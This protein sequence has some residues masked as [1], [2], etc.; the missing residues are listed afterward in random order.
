MSDFRLVA[1][2]FGGP[3]VIEAV[4]LEPIALSPGKVRVRHHAV[5][6]NFIDTYHRTGLYPQPLPAGLGVEAAGVVEAVGEGVSGWQAGDRV[7][8]A[9]AT[10]GSYA[11]WQDVDASRLL[12]LPDTIDD[13]TAAAILLKG[14]TVESL[15]NGCA[16]VQPG[17]SALVLAAAGG[18]GRM[19]VQWLSAIGVRVIAHAGSAE[20]A[21]IASALG[22]STSIDCPFEDLAATV[23][24][25]NGGKGVDVVF[26]GVGADSWT[27]SLDSLR[28][29]GLM[30]S[31]GN[32]SGPVAPFTPLELAKRG[33]LSVVRPRLYDYI[34]E[35]SELEAS[36]AALFAMV[37]DGRV[38]V[39]IGL[40][41]PL[42]EAADAH[43]ALE[44][45]ATTGSV[46][47]TV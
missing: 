4:A 36:A 13:E 32:A 7:G 35:R 20:K 22:A 33:S 12:A 37:A 42:A 44:G 38:K 17:Q 25:A 18:V 43:R 3:E 26:D 8:Y 14:L 46:I 27:A 1:P 5:G 11:S 40:R 31:F 47:L 16:H 34:T 29:R 41:M 19:L 28:P 6:V 45:R 39:E 21:A 9:I 23:R 2:A 15:V 30:V 24:A 10:P